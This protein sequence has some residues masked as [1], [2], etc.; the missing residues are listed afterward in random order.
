MSGYKS[1]YRILAL[2]LALITAAGG[3]LAQNSLTLINP[4]TQVEGRKFAVTFRA[5][6]GQ[7]TG[8]Q[9]PSLKGCKLIYGPSVSTMES[10]QYINGQM[11]RESYVDYSY[12]Y[13]AES[14][15]DVT[16][17][18]VS[19]TIG[20]QNVKSKSG[21]FTILPPDKNAP[22]QIRRPQ[23]GTPPQAQSGES[24]APP[25]KS[26]DL[27]VRVTFSK[28]KVYEQEPV[29]AEIKVYTRHG[30]SNFQVQT[31]PVFDGFLSEELDVPLSV[32][33]EHYNGQ[34]YYTAVLKRCI[35][36]PQKAGRLT[37]NSGKYDVTLQQEVPVY[38]G[39]FVTSKIIERK[40]T[41]TSNEVSLNVLPL[42]EPKPAGF[43]G[44]V[45]RFDIT[46]SLTPEQLRTNEAANYRIEISGSGNIKYLKAPDLQV[47]VGIDAY[48]PKTEVQSKAS[49]G[50]VSGVF[51]VDYTL[52]PQQVGDYTIPGIR[53]VYF[54]PQSASYKTANGR[55]FEFKVER[56]AAG[57]SNTKIAETAAMTDI[58]HIKQSEA[59][60]APYTTPLMLRA[61]YWYMLA[62][63]VVVF[64]IILWVYRRN[65]RLR[66]DVA[67]R[68]LSRASRVARRRLR[69]ANRLIKDS[70]DK[71]Y[72]ELS[73][74]LYGYFGD[75]LGMPPS[76]LIR[77]NIA[78][79]LADYGAS[80]ESIELAI[81]ILDDCEMA[82][83][84]P[85]HSQ[86]ER[87]SLY[88]DA[89]NVIKDFESVKQ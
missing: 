58:L 49:G 17:P 41:T 44:A 71:F 33:M 75:K 62:A 5:T 35:L 43:N 28:Q 18:A 11:T 80:N 70:G 32:N 3:V 6:G 45:G 78:Q 4:G 10:V 46:T 38:Y 20:G 42:P 13:L 16:V 14:A 88:R 65:V 30:I 21:N 61:A 2:L 48:T 54:D 39:Y 40:I 12:T 29:I 69:M 72:E 81:R 27:I 82:R 19:A 56:G 60:P 64:L 84:T 77:A 85:D 36:Y 76:Q 83:F 73:K 86:Q 25:I 31:Q 9:A 15:G 51:S 7:A 87:D 53:F 47:P 24:E 34:N 55:E 37:V 68:R 59:S 63:L 1:Q 50:N 79:Q 57:I 74:A 22:A 66:A 8:L 52:M 26:S 23:P 67:G 89:S